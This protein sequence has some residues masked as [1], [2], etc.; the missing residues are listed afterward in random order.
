MLQ[1]LPNPDAEPSTPSTPSPTLDWATGTNGIA[2]EDHSPL[3]FTLFLHHPCPPYISQMMILKFQ[4]W[5]D[6]YTLHPT[7]IVL[8]FPVRSSDSNNTVFPMWVFY[9]CISS[10]HPAHFLW[11]DLT[12]G[13]WFQNAFPPSHALILTSHDKRCWNA[14]GSL[15]RHILLWRCKDH[16]QIATHPSLSKREKQE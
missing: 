11:K 15:P 8:W 10:A 13:F 7:V 9:M 2:L 14:V 12:V 16:F 5:H 1:L 4:R 6:L 3:Q